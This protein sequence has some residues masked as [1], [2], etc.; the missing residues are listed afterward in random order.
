[1]NKR[2]IDG[3]QGKA[4]NMYG[5]RRKMLV[6]GKVVLP[7]LAIHDRWRVI[8]GTAKQ[9]DELRDVVHGHL[10]DGLELLEL[11]FQPIEE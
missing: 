11:E 5:E 3:T 6:M 2:D 10:D 8:S 1:M 4:R 7:T 9:R